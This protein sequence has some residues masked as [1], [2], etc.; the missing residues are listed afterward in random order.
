MLPDVSGS[1]CGRSGFLGVPQKVCTIILPFTAVLWWCTAAVILVWNVPFYFG[2]RPLR[3]LRVHDGHWPTHDFY[4]KA[5]W[6]GRNCPTKLPF[7]RRTFLRRLCQHSNTAT[8]FLKTY[9][10]RWISPQCF[11]KFCLTNC[12]V[13]MSCDRIKKKKRIYISSLDC[14]LTLNLS[15]VLGMHMFWGQSS[16]VLSV[17]ANGAYNYRVKQLCLNYN[18]VLQFFT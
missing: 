7:W 14:K 15:S 1:A 16:S 6:L 2:V 12:L 10:R 17:C 3:G 11:P 5:R 18:T 9:D 4:N 8:S 13:Q